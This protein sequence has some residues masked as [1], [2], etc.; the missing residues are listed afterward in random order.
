MTPAILMVLFIALAVV[1]EFR[2]DARCREHIRAWADHN[3]LRLEQVRR[4]WFGFGSLWRGRKRIY[5]VVAIDA[6]G[7]QQ[8]ALLRV[9]GWNSGAFSDQVDVRWG[10]TR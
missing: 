2:G 1:F 6:E 8:V 5:D 10:R 3:G 4:D 9:G 7:R